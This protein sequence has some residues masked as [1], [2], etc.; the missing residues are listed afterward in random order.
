MK[1]LLYIFIFLT[2]PIIGIGQTFSENYVKT[3]TYLVPVDTLTENTVQ[4]INKIEQISYADGLGR[5]IQSIAVRAGGQG[6]HIISHQEYDALGRSP[7]QYL[8]FPL[9]S[10]AAS[11]V[12]PLTLKD[13]HLLKEDILS[14]YDTSK[15]ENTLNPYSEMR[16]ENS[17]LNRVLVTRLFPLE[18]IIRTLPSG[19]STYVRFPKS[20]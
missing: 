15:Y 10:D 14:F 2:F 16:Y 13:A 12:N 5:P 7:K 11:E 3:T 20:S 17:P 19:D 8:P 6:Q 4:D 1:K 18:L 9:E